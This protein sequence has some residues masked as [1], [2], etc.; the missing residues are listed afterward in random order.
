MK[1][2]LITSLLILSV[3]SFSGCFGNNRKAEGKEYLKL[4]RLSQA[5]LT[6]TQANKKRKLY[7]E[8]VKTTEGQKIINKAVDEYFYRT[9][10]F[11]Q[12]QREDYKKLYGVYP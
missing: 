12:K 9:S 8:L 2:I 10:H 4:S 11:T 3:L 5:K 7:K 6:P 1:K